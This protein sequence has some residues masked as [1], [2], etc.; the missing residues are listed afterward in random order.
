M[1]SLLISVL[2]TAFSTSPLVAEDSGPDRNNAEFIVSSLTQQLITELPDSNRTASFY[3]RTNLPD[4]HH[5]RL[6]D[7][8]VEEGYQIKSSRSEHD[9]GI[10]VEIEPVL[11]LERTGR[12]QASR[13]LEM[14]YS[15]HIIAPDETIVDSIRG[16]LEQT[17]TVN[18][19]NRDDLVTEWPATRFTDVTDSTRRRWISAAAEPVALIGATA[20]AV[21][22]LYNVR[23]D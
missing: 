6:V 15:I 18:Y 8:L 19:R 11:L 23:S 14:D 3:F 21:V 9:Q 20:V 1:P 16:S 2:L 5:R 10:E 13:F 12:R 17:D 4:N 7:A 22:L